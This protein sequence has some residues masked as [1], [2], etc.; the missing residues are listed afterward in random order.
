MGAV[1]IVPFG[2]A[3]DCI[4]GSLA[5]AWRGNTPLDGGGDLVRG[6]HER[7]APPMQAAVAALGGGRGPPAQEL[8]VPPGAGAQPV[9]D[10]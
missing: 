7:P 8:R 6:G 1:W 2:V 9:P 10:S 3:K 5:T 4:C